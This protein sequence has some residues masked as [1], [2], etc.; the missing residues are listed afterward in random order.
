MLFLNNIFL[1]LQSDPSFRFHRTSANLRKITQTNINKQEEHKDPQ[2]TPCFFMLFWFHSF[3][4]KVRSNRNEVLSKKFG[5][6]VVSLEHRYCGKFSPFNS[7]TNE[8]LRYLSSK[9]ALFDLAIFRQFCK[10]IK[11]TLYHST[12]CS[13]CLSDK[14]HTISNFTF[15]T[16]IDGDFFYFLADA[17]TIG[18]QYGNPGTVCSS[19]VEAKKNGDDLVESYAKYFGVSV[20]TYNQEHLKNTTL[21]GFSS[22]RLWWFQV[23]TEVAYFQAALSND[24]IR[25]SKVDT[26]Y[27]L[28]RYRNVF[29]EGIYLDVTA[30]NIYCGGTNIEGRQVIF[31][32]GSQDPWRH[33]SKQ[34]SSP[35]CDNCPKLKIKKNKKIK[36]KKISSLKIRSEFSSIFNKWVS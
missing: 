32:N 27:H 21:T 5:A 15:K 10:T 25:S 30:A 29:E 1:F 22:D 14:T 33:A 4:N 36:K 16:F 9:L 34:P 17:A 31:T 20:G 7:L 19:L 35:D 2:V 28:D 24:S 11:I 13:S 23:C 6:A 18:F 12:T 26:R 3:F 8:N